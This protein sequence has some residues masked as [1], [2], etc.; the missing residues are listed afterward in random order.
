MSLKRKEHNVRN[1][2]FIGVIC[3][4]IVEIGKKKNMKRLAWC[5]IIKIIIGGNNGRRESIKSKRAG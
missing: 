2:N 4:F 1:I 5:D 3:R